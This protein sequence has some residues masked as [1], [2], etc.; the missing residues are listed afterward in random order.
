M[1][2]GENTCGGDDVRSTSRMPPGALRDCLASGTDLRVL[3]VRTP[4]EFRTA[5][6]PGSWNVPL[7]SLGEC[8]ADLVAGLSGSVVLVC[9]SGARAEKAARALQEAGL[10]SMS[11]LEGGIAAWEREGGA[12]DRGRRG[13]ELE[14]QVRLAAGVLVLLGVLGSL[15]L[16]A[17]VW[18]SAFVGAGLVFAAVTD[19]CGMALLLARM[20]WN[21]A[22]PT[23][24]RAVV[25]QLAACRRVER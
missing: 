7:D 11:V 2:D 6:I 13:W 20:P 25:A 16:P 21:R 23:D 17:L 3:D 14:R 15:A 24:V 4:A 8:R 22:A 9:R 19:H 12:L 18:L 5:H 1:T 10:E